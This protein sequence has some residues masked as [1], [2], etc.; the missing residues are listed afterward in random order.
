[1][2]WLGII[3]IVIVIIFAA[4]GVRRGL[5][6]GTIDVALVVIS[7]LAAAVGYHEASKIFSRFFHLSAVTS[8]I[9]GFILILI[10]VQVVITF[11]LSVTVFPMIGVARSFPPLRVAD[12]TLGLLPGLLKGLVVA[13]ILVMALSLLPINGRLSDALGSSSIA[14]HVMRRTVDVVNWGE[15]RTH[16]NLSD[17][18]IMVEPSSEAGIKLPF[19]V[20]NGLQ[21]SPSDE[22]QM[23]TLLNQSRREN[24][25]APLTLDPTL[26]DVARAHSEEMFRLGYF[27]HDSPVSGSPFARMKAAGVND[28]AMGENLAYAPSV[29]VAERGLMRSPGHRANILSPDFSKVGIGVVVA[30]N[31][32]KMFTQ[33]FAG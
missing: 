2:N 22:Q 9:L 18:T 7:L 20:T 32:S 27:A 13:G 28:P 19:K 33:D 30:P 15:Q 17:F 23:L 12:D 24:G 8:N 4:E 21:V 1:M 5:L 11:V 16:L 6:R 31:G 25:L 29:D 10:V 26:R 3:L 14:Q